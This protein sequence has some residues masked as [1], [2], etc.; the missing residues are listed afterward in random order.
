MDKKIDLIVI[1]T[2]II[3]SAF[4]ALRFNL[5]PLIVA[6]FAL[7]IPSLYLVLRKKKNWPKVLL[8]TLVFGGIFGFI[9]D[10]I[11]TLNGAWYVERL[12]I[13]WRVLGILPIDDVIGLMFM[14]FFII[15]FYEHFIDDEKNKRLSKN[16]VW[17]L[18]PSALV[19]LVIILVFLQTGAQKFN[20]S[21]IYLKGGLVAIILPVLM[22][23]WKPKLWDKLLKTGIFFFFL[24]F[25]SEIVALKTGGWT[26]PGQYIGTVSVLGVTFPFEELF[27]W[28]MMY[29]ASIVS[30]YEL[31][32]D[33][34]K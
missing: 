1:C 23:I 14:T 29:A 34:I 6:I 28:M 8:G 32:I 10:F 13:P 27:F 30:Y 5:R 4:I 33:D 26:F 24:W 17:S 20:M 7:F 25:I 16:F 12:V 19:M 21:F 18:I 31:F 11:E 2:I 9:F 22:G 15:V 3:I